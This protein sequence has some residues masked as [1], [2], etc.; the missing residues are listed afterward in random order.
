MEKKKKPMY[1]IEGQKQVRQAN[2]LCRTQTN[3]VSSYK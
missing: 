2:N 3:V 1:K